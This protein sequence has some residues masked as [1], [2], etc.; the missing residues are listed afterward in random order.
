[1]RGMIAVLNAGL[2]SIKFA[3]HE[4]ATNGPASLRGQIQG[5]GSKPS[6]AVRN[7]ASEILAEQS[8]PAEG[9]DH[10]AATR[11]VFETIT[12]LIGGKRVA[13][14]GHRVM[15]GGM[16]FDAPVRIDAQILAE[17]ERCIPLAPLHQPHNLAPI[18]AIA[19]RADSPDCVLRYCLP[20]RPARGRAEV[21][22]AAP[23]S[24]CG[25][26]ALRFPRLVL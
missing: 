19:E 23:S 3:L 7:A 17:L 20:S 16:S 12:G 13:A 10:S 15:H 24:R 8:W 22:L 1:M 4:A 11:A 2:S 5:I 21:C 18:R 25:G 14:I 26:Q 6:L 9:F